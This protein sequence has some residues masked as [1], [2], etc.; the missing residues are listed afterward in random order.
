MRHVCVAAALTA[1]LALAAGCAKVTSVDYYGLNRSAPHVL[2]GNAACPDPPA[3]PDGFT[4]GLCYT[5]AGMTSAGDTLTAGE[6]ASAGGRFRAGARSDFGLEYGLT[7]KYSAVHADGRLMLA[8]SPLRLGL[9]FGGGVAGAAGGTAYS[10]DYS[11]LTGVPLFGDRALV[12]V[13]PG[14][15]HI[16]YIWKRVTVDN[17]EDTVVS[18]YA[19]A[20]RV[21]AGVRISIPAG[22]ST[23]IRIRPELTYLGG[24]EP[25]LTRGRYQVLE[26]ALSIEYDF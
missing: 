21:S 13:S 10:I 25:A 16:R 20:V 14:M 5:H 2:P 19:N 7:G 26:P 24:K 8:D 6:R 1:S 11:L 17:G 3:G 18:A 22:D 4:A 15:A 9:D 23:F 12:Y